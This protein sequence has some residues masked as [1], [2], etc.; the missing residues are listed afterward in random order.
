MLC[1]NLSNAFYAYILISLHPAQFHLIDFWCVL[2]VTYLLPIVNIAPYP[3]FKCCWWR[4]NL[5]RFSIFDFDSEQRMKNRN[6]VSWSMWLRSATYRLQVHSHTS[7]IAAYKK[8]FYWP[9]A[10]SRGLKIHLII[11]SLWRFKR[12]CFL[13]LDFLYGC[14]DWGWVLRVVLDFE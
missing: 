8:P 1:L 5:N 10:W 9:R 2:Q 3:L 7:W 4:Q 13:K 12:S 14:M 6:I 11:V